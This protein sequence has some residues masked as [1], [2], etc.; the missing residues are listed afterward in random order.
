MG[1]SRTYYVSS[2]HGNDQNDG[3]SP[4]HPFCTLDRANRLKLEPGD[5]I[6]LECGSVF[7]NQ[8]LRITD[9]GS[10]E[11]PIEIG[12]Y[13]E[14]VFPAIHANG[15][16]LWYQDY[17]TPLDS[18]AH[19]Y[20]GYVSSAV[21]LYDA[22]YIYIH[23]IEI[24]NRSD[25][26][27]GEQY[28]APHKMDRTGVAVVAKDKGTL[29]GIHLDNLY[30]HDVHGNIYNKHMNNGGIYMTALKPSDEE[31]TGT[32]RYEDITI[33]NCFV[34]RVSR[35]GI[36]VGYTYQ[37]ERFKEAE[38]LDELFP[39]YGH[40]NIVIRNNYVKETGGDGITA[41]Y[42][43]RPLIEH[44]TADCTAQEMND[45][46]YKYPE[47]RMGKVAAA[48]WPWKCKDALLRYNEAVDTRLNQD[49]M[50]YDADSGD[51]T[52]YEY[53]YSRLNEGGCVMFCLEQ[54]VHNFFCHNISYDDLGGTISP[55]GN[56]DA[57]IAHNTF[58]VREGVPFVRNNMDGGKYTEEKNTIKQL[59]TGYF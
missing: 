26:I 12:K 11:V 54:A 40:E 30:I 45:R 28:E 33:E 3:C 5:K 20:K 57:Y 47:G 51:G 42:A 59:G 19:V 31:K 56:P 18:A 34:R 44:N 38:L 35:W 55:S 7:E 53:N 52:R 46:V 4:E 16:G 15:N 1:L 6:L 50:A 49:G 17:G 27:P 43:Y 8:Y 13:G 14:G 2:K 10:G 39:A 22:S 29:H 21:L 48:I 58:Y 23:D 37:H 36:A 25:G 32:A 41:M 24:T 9:S